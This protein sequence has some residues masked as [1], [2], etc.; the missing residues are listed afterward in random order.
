MIIFNFSH[1]IA[2]YARHICE[3]YSLIFGKGVAVEAARES[4]FEKDASLVEPS[5]AVQARCITFQKML[6]YRLILKISR[7]SRA[8]I[9]EIEV[10]CLDSQK[11]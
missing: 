8:Q 3:T 11:T 5:A 7:E 4:V 1:Y 2:Q 10:S 9:D 6:F